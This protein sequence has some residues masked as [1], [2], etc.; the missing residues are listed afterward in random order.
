VG[1]Y[2]QLGS[3]KYHEYNEA[4]PLLRGEAAG[5]VARIEAWA[6]EYIPAE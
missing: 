3:S 2:P 1:L 6:E 4:W 5:L